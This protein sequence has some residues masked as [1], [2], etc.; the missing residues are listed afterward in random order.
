MS[1]S[2]S[3]EEEEEEDYGIKR[4]FEGFP[5]RDQIGGGTGSLSGSSRIES[6]IMPSMRVESSMVIAASSTKGC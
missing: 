4:C 2:Q 1:V 6:G 3:E 5:Q